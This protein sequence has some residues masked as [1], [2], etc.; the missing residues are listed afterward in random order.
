MTY[1]FHFT[2]EKHDNTDRLW[3]TCFLKG[4]SQKEVEEKAKRCM[5]EFKNPKLVALRLEKE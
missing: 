1:F 2:Y 4:N 5:S 3:Y